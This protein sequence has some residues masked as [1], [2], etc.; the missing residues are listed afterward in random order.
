MRCNDILAGTVGK[1]VS[2]L[3]LDLKLDEKDWS[4]CSHLAPLRKNLSE[5]R[6]NVGEAE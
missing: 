3:S 2:S 4:C 6:A 5:D 1:E